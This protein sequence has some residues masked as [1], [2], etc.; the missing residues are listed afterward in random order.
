MLTA[1]KAYAL[2]SVLSCLLLSGSWDAEILQAR[3]NALIHALP[4]GLQLCFLLTSS[5]GEELRL[6]ELV[7]VVGGTRTHL[8][9]P[10]WS[11]SYK[12]VQLQSSHTRG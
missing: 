10:A 3:R 11:N 6:Q 4:Q 7:D 2:T 5:L 1:C 9:I 12:S 8:L